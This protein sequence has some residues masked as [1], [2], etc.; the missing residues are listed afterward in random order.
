MTDEKSTIQDMSDHSDMTVRELDEMA[1]IGLLN[2]VSLLIDA[3]IDR[4]EFQRYL[5]MVNGAVAELAF[6]AEE[7]RE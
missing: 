3:D 4:D 5:D 6:R 1:A 7:A 2:L